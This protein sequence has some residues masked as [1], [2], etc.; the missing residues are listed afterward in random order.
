MSVDQRDARHRVQLAGALVEHELDVR[1]RL[2]T[3]TEARL[4]LAHALR[5]GADPAALRRVHVED[6]IGLPEPERPQ[7]HGLRLQRPRHGASVGLA[8]A[9]LAGAQATSASRR[10]VAGA[11]GAR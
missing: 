11:R 8:G 2:Q 4:R 10:S 6:A 1:E 9:G 5:D 7:H 3:R